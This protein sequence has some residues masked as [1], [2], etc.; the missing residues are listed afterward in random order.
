MKKI[1]HKM[2]IETGS[3]LHRSLPIEIDVNLDNVLYARH[4][5]DY[6]GVIL[7]FVDGSETLVTTLSYDRVMKGE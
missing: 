7:H 2:H 3:G 5:N 4:P 6:R 1:F